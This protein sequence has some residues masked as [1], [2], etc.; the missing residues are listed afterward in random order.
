MKYVVLQ[1]D[2]MADEPIAELGGKTPLETGGGGA[3]IMRDF[4]AGHPPT[5]EAA[6]IV[7]DLGRALGGN[8]LEFHPGV[9]YRHLLVWRGGEVHMRTTPRHDLSDKPV[10]G[11]FPQGPGADVLCN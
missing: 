8:G 4:A 6:E 1:G 7:R 10:A 2:G 5:E 11:H 3:E 9:S